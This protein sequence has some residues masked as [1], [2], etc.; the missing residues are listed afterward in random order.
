M[1]FQFLPAYCGFQLQSIVTLTQG[2]SRLLQLILLTGTPPSQV[3]PT[4]VFTLFNLSHSALQ[5]LFSQHST[6]DSFTIFL[7]QEVPHDKYLSLIALT[8][9]DRTLTL[10][11]TPLLFLDS[12]YRLLNN[13]PGLHS[14]YSYT[15]LN[16]T[17]QQFSLTFPSFSPLLCFVESF[18]SYSH[19][20][21]LLSKITLLLISALAFIQSY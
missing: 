18:C 20:H 19:N 21:I 3:Y 15:R 4:I 2:N 8:L 12:L 11:N 10:S 1:A 6:G 16:S 7:S 14:K 17:S 13:V 9:L 5:G